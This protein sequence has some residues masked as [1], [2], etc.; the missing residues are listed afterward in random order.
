MIVLKKKYPEFTWIC[1][2][3]IEDGCSRKRPDLL[4]DFGTHII[5]IEIDENKHS[6][7]DCSCENKRLMM[8]SQD[9]NHR[10]IIFIRFNPDGYVDK[11]GKKIKTCWKEGVK[12]IMVI[13]N[14]KKEEWNNRLNMLHEQIKYW[15]ENPSNKMIEIIELFY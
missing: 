10:P 6:T 2:K 12:G 15:V 8:I 14:D 4:A 13:K 3:K 7:Y 9:V 11:D 1:D 5:I